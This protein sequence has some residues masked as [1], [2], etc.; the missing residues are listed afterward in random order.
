MATQNPLLEL[1]RLGQSI[2][3]DDI[4]R[5]MLADG[6]LAKLIKDDGVAGVTSN[7]SILAHSITS[8]PQYAQAI[9]DLLPKVSGS[10]MRSSP[11]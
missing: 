10:R 2:W 11:P 1:H 9:K 6:S 4:G 7:P 3:L 8:D 5:K